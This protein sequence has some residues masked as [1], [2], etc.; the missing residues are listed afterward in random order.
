MCHCDKIVVVEEKIN[1]RNKTLTYRA[2]LLS[3]I[4]P[5]HRQVNELNLALER[6]YFLVVYAAAAN[7][8]VGFSTIIIHENIPVAQV[9]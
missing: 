6:Q 1:K 2:V 4:L 8:H 9:P 5:R 7:E 3:V